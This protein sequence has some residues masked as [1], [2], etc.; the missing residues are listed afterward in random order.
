MSY[1]NVKCRVMVKQN[2]GLACDHLR[3]AVD[4]PDNGEVGVILGMGRS[5]ISQ[6][7]D[8]VRQR[9]FV[10]CTDDVFRR[11][12]S[13]FHFYSNLTFVQIRWVS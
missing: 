12:L 4:L 3:K 9:C 7:L 10:P 8:D 6:R 11:S 1:V 13:L 2:C 5:W